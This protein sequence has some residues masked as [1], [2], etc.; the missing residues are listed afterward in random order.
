MTFIT[1]CDEEFDD[2][3]VKLLYPSGCNK[4]YC[5]PEIEDSCHLDK[6]YLENIGG[7]ILKIRNSKDPILL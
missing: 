7:S 2:F 5:Y 3:K 1:S 4:H 6:K